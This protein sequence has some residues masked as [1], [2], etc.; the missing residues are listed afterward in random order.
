[1]GEGTTRKHFLIIALGLGVVLLFGG[2]FWGYLSAMGDRSAGGAKD[3]PRV[4][5][6]AGRQVPAAR[7]QLKPFVL[8]SAID[9]AMIDSNSFAGKVLLVSFF[10]TWCPPCR[11]EAPVFKKLQENFEPQGFSVVGLSMDQDRPKAVAAK[12]RDWGVNY[13][14][15]L[16]DQKVVDSFGDITGIPVTFL[17]NRAGQVLARYEGLTEH[18]VL[19]D[20]IRKNL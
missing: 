13:P 1:M 9:G 12:L 17:V 8:P 14:V 5:T 15:L 18:S 16:A 19:E 10:A 6:I 7:M 2:G 11:A 20:A 4:Q 3:R